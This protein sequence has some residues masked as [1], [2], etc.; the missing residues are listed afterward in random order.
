LSFG[1]SKTQTGDAATAT[2]QEAKLFLAP[3]IVVP[4]GSHVIV[5]QHGMTR[6]YNLSSIPAVYPT[7]Q[8]ISFSAKD[9]WA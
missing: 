7:H 6:E 8:E 3:E 1:A 4:A 9:R 5:T 2:A